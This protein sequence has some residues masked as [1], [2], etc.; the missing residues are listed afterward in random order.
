LGSIPDSWNDNIKN[1]V[2]FNSSEDEFRSIDEDW[3]NAKI[4]PDQINGI[5][6][7]CSTLQK[8][9]PEARIYL[10]I[11]PNL[12]NIK[13]KYHTSLLTLS[14]EFPNLTVIP[15]DSK[16]SSY[17]LMHKAYRVIVFGS[18]MGIESAYAKKIVINLHGSL[19]DSL[20]ICYKPRSIDEFRSM[21]LNDSLPV[22]DNYNCLKFGYSVLNTDV[23]NYI[24]LNN[25]RKSRKEKILDAYLNYNLVELFKSGIYK[26]RIKFMNDELPVPVKE[27]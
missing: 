17:S 20:N 23:P 2:I 26:F 24:Y 21:L 11:H 12:K 1:Y 5:R 9:R 6:F 19:Y 10:R 4:F 27:V 15:G 16:I 18:T 25:D 13:Y 7:I 22:L 3:D 8:E 14:S